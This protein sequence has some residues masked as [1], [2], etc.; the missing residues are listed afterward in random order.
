MHSEH[1]SPLNHVLFTTGEPETPDP[2][3]EGG[4]EM[5]LSQGQYQHYDSQFQENV[6]PAITGM[7]T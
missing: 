5:Q 4:F 1:V 7:G 2:S 3:V 6:A